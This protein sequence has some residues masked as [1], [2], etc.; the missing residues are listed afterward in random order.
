MEYV[1][2][3]VQREIIKNHIF[4]NKQNEFE[5]FVLD[6]MNQMLEEFD[7][8]YSMEFDLLLKKFFEFVPAFK[9]KKEI[10][11]SLN[12]DFRRSS[13][14]EKEFNKFFDD[15][16]SSLVNRIAVFIIQEGFM[17]R[18][19][20]AVLRCDYLIE[21]DEVNDILSYWA[22]KKVDVISFE[23]GFEYDFEED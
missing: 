11:D 17:N 22:P 1:G 10:L 18:L 14:T 23:Y 20:E 4:D 16:V 6:I 7:Y 19:N 9:V 8:G 12:I 2:D 5:S 21:E 3:D 13:M 15:F